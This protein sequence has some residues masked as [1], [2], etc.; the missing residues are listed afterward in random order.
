MRQKEV[1]KIKAVLYLFLLT[2]SIRYLQLSHTLPIILVHLLEEIFEVIFSH[3][4]VNEFHANLTT[5]LTNTHN[6]DKQG[7]T[8][9]RLQGG[10][11]KTLTPLHP[12][13][14][15]NITFLVF[16]WQWSG[17]TF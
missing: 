10:Q 3:C 6:L 5:P 17:G 15:K 11:I 8:H 9:G 4:F 14:L 1:R 12:G 2:R 13:P 7:G 16:L